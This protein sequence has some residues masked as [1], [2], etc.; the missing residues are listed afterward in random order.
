MLIKCLNN[1][2][3]NRKANLTKLCARKCFVDNQLYKE[4]EKKNLAVLK[5]ENKTPLYDC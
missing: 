5:E 2:I 3:S 4:I 1:L